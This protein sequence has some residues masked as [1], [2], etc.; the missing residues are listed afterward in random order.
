MLEKINWEPLMEI[1]YPF[2]LYQ[3]PEAK[4]KLVPFDALL[5]EQ[6]KRMKANPNQHHGLCCIFMDPEW[7][8]AK[9]EIDIKAKVKKCPSKTTKSTKK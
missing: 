5:M 8:K 3:V 2:P 1:L 6:K 9:E 7:R 4:G